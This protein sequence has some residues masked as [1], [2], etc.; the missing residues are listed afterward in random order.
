MSKDHSFICDGENDLPNKEFSL[1]EQMD[2]LNLINL[3]EKNDEKLNDKYLKIID[4]LTGEYVGYEKIQNGRI[5]F[6]DTNR[7]IEQYR[8][9][10]EKIDESSDELSFKNSLE[11]KKAMLKEENRLQN[12]IMKT[13][14][15]NSSFHV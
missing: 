12:E 13:Q 7:L 9:I 2:R 15:N 5:R 11:L 10:L 8:K 1:N 6:N 3:I 14:S 4:Q